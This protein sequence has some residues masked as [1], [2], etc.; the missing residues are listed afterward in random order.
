MLISSSNIPQADSLEDVLAVAIAVHRGARSFQEIAA[1]IHKVERQGRYYRKSAELIGLITNDNNQSQ[2]TDLGLRIATARSTNKRELALNAV[3]GLELIRRVVFFL[4][5]HPDGVSRIALEDFIG[6]VTQHVGPSMIPRRVST[7]IS[8][9]TTLN[10][11][12]RMP[13]E[14]LRLVAQTDLRPK[15]VEVKD[16]IEPLIPRQHPLADYATVEQRVTTARPAISVLLNDVARERANKAHR[17]LVNLV[18]TRLRGSGAIPRSNPLIDLSA[19]VE[20]VPLIFEM[21][22]TTQVNAHNQVRR[23]ISQLYEYRYLQNLP[24]ARLVIVIELPLHNSVAWMK[25]Y[26][27]EDRQISLIWNGKNELHADRATRD[28]LPYLGLGA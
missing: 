18:A 1:A 4:D 17:Q 13:D 24:D 10:L 22:S 23:A 27:E 19:Q 16:I 20:D 2:L 5:L 15:Q 9:L 6:S 12:E 14:S 25:R 3:L 28:A 8:W 21:K 7:V 11:L 26:L